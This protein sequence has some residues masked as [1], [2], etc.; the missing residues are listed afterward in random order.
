MNIVR[1]NREMTGWHFLAI[2]VA[3][4]SVVIAVNLTMAFL[5]SSSWTG[6]V[7]ENTYVA[8]QKF[9]E[10]AAEGRAQAALHWTST[11][12]IA[13]GKVSYRLVDSVGNVVAAKRATANFRRPAYASED[14]KLDLLPQPDGSLAAPVDAGDGMWIVEIDAEAGLARPYRD[15]R[16]LTLRNGMIQ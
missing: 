13:D 2:M 8:S 9:N 1:R 6:F 12:T 7:V 4:F 3:F 11:L 5:A 10:K 15:V 14:Q 16:R